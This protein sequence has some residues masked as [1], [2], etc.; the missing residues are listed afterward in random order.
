MRNKANTRQCISCRIKNN[1]INL[2]KL[3]L[4]DGEIVVD[5]TQKMMHRGYYICKQHECIEK[6][7]GSKILNRTFK[8][9]INDAN[10]DR[11]IKELRD[12]D[13]N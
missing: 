5:K 8:M 9:Q 6:L 2:I 3:C 13:A 7:I 12:F 11:L 4:I 1:K 10:K